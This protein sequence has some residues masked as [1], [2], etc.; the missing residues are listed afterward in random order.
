M[1]QTGI[2]WAEAV[3][4]RLDYRL[5][6]LWL[7]LE[8]ATWT[9]LPIPPDQAAEKIARE[10]VRERAAKRYNGQWSHVLDAWITTLL[11][12]APQATVSAFP[13]VSGLDAAFTLGRRTGYSLSGVGK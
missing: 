12:T 10:F 5:D 9:S 13:G 4:I 7:L 6:R 11:G 8:P 3:R 2:T 1:P